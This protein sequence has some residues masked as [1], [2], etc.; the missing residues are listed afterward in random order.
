MSIYSRKLTPYQ[1]EDMQQAFIDG[2]SIKGLA[3]RYGVSPTTVHGHVAKVRHLRTAPVVQRL[4]D[5]GDVAATED[6]TEDLPSINR[7]F[8]R[9]LHQEALAWLL[10]SRKQA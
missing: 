10:L 1:V 6:K 3:Q 8:L 2:A 7:A 4:R 5:W 9:A